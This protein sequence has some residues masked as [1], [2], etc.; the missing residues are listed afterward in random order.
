MSFWIGRFSHML[1]LNEHSQF[2]LLSSN[3]SGAVRIAVFLSQ[4]LFSQEVIAKFHYKSN[5]ILCNTA[6][7]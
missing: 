6:D 3:F 5:D 4:T 2:K 1:R 7:I